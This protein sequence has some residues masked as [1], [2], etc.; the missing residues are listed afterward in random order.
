VLFQRRFVLV[1]M[2]LAGTIVAGC[3]GGSTPAPP[4]AQ[5][6]AAPGSSITSLVAVPGTAGSLALSSIGGNTPSFGI[7]AG[8]PAGLTLTATES[9]I[10]P[11]HAP[12]ILA[13]AVRK[14]ASAT[15][16]PVTPFLFI[17]A[18]FSAAVPSGIVASEV[19]ALASTLPQIANYFCEIDDITGGTA[20]PLGTIGP[21]VPVNGSATFGNGSGGAGQGLAAGHT[22]LFQFYEL[23]IPAPT[24]T[25][26][27]T[28][29]STATATPSAAP[30]TTQSPAVS[31]TIT[32]TPT[33]TG[34]ATPVPAFTFSGPSVS[35]PS[36]NP[37]AA[38]AAMVVPATGSY[39]TFGAQATVT[40]GSS[41]GS[42]AF[43]L[44]T[45]L[46]T[47]GDI[48]PG[49]QFPLY[50]GS[51]ATPLFYVLVSTT[52]A[53]SF[54]QSPAITVTVSHG[55]GSTNTCGLYIYADTGSG[56]FSWQLVPG[57]QANVSGNS[58]TIP[59]VSLGSNT[60][61]LAPG[62]TTLA[63]VGC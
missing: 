45:A 32:P 51:A 35:A 4:T 28:A 25:P 9:L 49:N 22:Y 14:T 24:P 36:A 20:S 40:W 7:N 26:T 33:P 56:P 23:P 44:S 3:S 2:F 59:A 47:P 38:P 42:S 13:S 17:T 41:S 19:I 60:A 62:K 29:T 53:V 27:A 1:T 6:T 55:F 12:V 52:A 63:F 43:V 37:S 18:T 58:V 34:P 21:I 16:S 8:A 30:S 50:T 61:D 39:G 57:A 48:S 54:S 11:P 15:P 46:G 10:A 31:P 5:P